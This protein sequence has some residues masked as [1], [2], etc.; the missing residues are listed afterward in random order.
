MK[1]ETKQQFITAFDKLYAETCE[2]GLDF[3]HTWMDGFQN[4]IRRGHTDH[5]DDNTYLREEEPNYS[6]YKAG[7]KAAMI[8]LSLKSHE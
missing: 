5:D 1:E 6:N 2:F 4:M 3:P 8:F 7:A